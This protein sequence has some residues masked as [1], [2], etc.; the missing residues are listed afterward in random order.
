MIRSMHK[1]AGVA[2]ALALSLVAT[3][4]CNDLLDVTLPASLTDA[5]LDDPTGAETVRNSVINEFESAYNQM[6]WE[7]YSR[8]DGGGTLLSSPGV[9]RFGAGYESTPGPWFQQMASSR[10]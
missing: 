5:A 2:L 10:R 3:A 6:V 1:R 8:E 4:G 9:D 7:F